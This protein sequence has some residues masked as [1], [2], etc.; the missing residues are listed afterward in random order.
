M[1]KVLGDILHAIDGGDLAMLTLLDLSA[2]FDTVNHLI[3]LQHLRTSYGIHGHVVNWF[4]SYL[5]GRTQSIRCGTSR[6]APGSVSYGVPY[7][8]VLGSIL[9]FLYTEDLLQL[10]RNHG[11]CS[12]LYADDTQIY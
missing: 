11:L 3:L 1:L 5:D 9:F 8:S 10:L 2:A 7:G 4:E 6:L 12:H